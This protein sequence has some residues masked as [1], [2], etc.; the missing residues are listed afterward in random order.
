M[1]LQ[2][3]KR[4]IIVE[5]EGAGT[6]GTD[7]LPDGADAVLVTDLNPSP[8]QGDEVERNLVRP[9]LGASE[10][11]MA[12]VRSGNEFSV[13]LAGSGTAGA[14]PRP[15]RLIRACGFAE[16]N[17][18]PAVT[19]T[20]T[21][22]ALNS[23]TLAAG[24]S[25]TNGFYN[26]MI[27]R[28]TAGVGAGTVALVTGYVGSTRVA[29][30]LPLGGSVTPTTTSVYSI[31][32]QTAYTPVS[33]LYSSCTIYT[34]IDK[35]VH[36]SPGNRGTFSLNA[37]VGGI[38]SLGFSMTG[39]YTAPADVVPPTAA[40]GDQATP[41]IVRQ[42]SSGGF[43]LLGY[44]GCL[45]SVSLDI[46]NS[47]NYSERIGCIKEVSIDA[48]SITGNI[49][50][51]APTIAQID[52]FTAAL[53]DSLLGELSFIHGTTANNIVGLYSNRVKVG[54]PAYEDLN[55]TQ[56]LRVPVTLVPNP[57]TGGNDEL[58]LVFA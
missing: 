15:G 33:D 24:A 43:R 7:A 20:A 19:G 18:T 47:V 8:M 3:N 39:L 6:Y 51:E 50:I 32:L 25:A 4:W 23:I 46:G 14:A 27:L 11:F 12:N 31:G 38:P 49:L 2:T 34:Y 13:E 44:S 52:Y 35:I 17:T 54:A 55:G 30:L 1:G 37:E 48:R 21:A 40:Y 57:S 16:T 28:I 29:T 22:G 36:R 58:R 10:R 9:F 26:G 56:M 45:Q 41:N 5:S 53:N 42:G